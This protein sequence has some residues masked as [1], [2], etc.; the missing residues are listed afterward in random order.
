MLLDLLTEGGNTQ[1]GLVATAAGMHAD[2]RLDQ[3]DWTACVDNRDW[4]VFV[5][6]DPPSRQMG[7]K[8]VVAKTFQGEVAFAR[9]RNR[10]VHALI[11]A[12]S[13]GPDGQLNGTVLSGLLAE[14]ADLQKEYE[15]D[16]DL[17]IPYSQVRI[18]C[19]YE[20]TNGPI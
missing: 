18:F 17:F 4:A 3:P 11:A 13:S 16:K 7:R 1:A 19:P 8:E 9:L 14:L 12:I 20:L 6:W 5:T 15:A 2:P 10:L